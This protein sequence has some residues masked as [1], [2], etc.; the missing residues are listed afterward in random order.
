MSSAAVVVE[1]DDQQDDQRV[2]DYAV[3]EALLGCGE[4]VLVTPYREYRTSPSG[5]ASAEAAAVLRE[6]AGRLE[7]RY[8][9]QLTVSVLSMEGSRAKV[10]VRAAEGARIV[11]VGRSAGGGP[12]GLRAAQS[13]LRVATAAHC[14]VVVV[15]RRWRSSPASS[16]VVVG[17][18]G[19]PLSLEAVA[20]AFE[21][22][23]GRGS[24]LR[25]VH[26]YWMRYG[27]PYGAHDWLGSAQLTVSESL[28]G[29]DEKYPNVRVSRLLT[30]RPILDTLASESA[31]AELVVVGAH[32][33]AGAIGDPITRRAIAETNCPIAIVAH[34]ATSAAPG[35]HVRLAVT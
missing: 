4:L 11:V 3:R 29:W 5:S 34:T 9:A 32:A 28:A 35:Q 24:E 6:T 2:L 21:V 17:V 14:P 23:A 33:G 30:T 22:A 18:D 8:G 19:T 31:Y 25:V 20:Y 26:S 1:L 13:S 27:S 10:M 12:S 15:P 7:Q 16:G